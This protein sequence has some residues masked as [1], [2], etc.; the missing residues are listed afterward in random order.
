MATCKI[1]SIVLIAVLLLCSIILLRPHHAHAIMVGTTANAGDVIINEVQY[2]PP[3]SGTDAAWEWVELYNPTNASVDLSGWTIGDNAANDSVPSFFLPPGKFAI[4]AA[5]ANF[6][7]NFP[8][9]TCTIVYMADGAIGNGLNNTGDRVILKDSAG[10]TIDAISYGTDTTYTTLPDVAAGH[11]LER[12][13][14][15]GSFI[16]NPNPSPCPSS[17]TATATPS[18]TPTATPSPSPTSTSTPT[19]SPTST[20]TPT[21]SPTSTS[22]PTASPT[23]TPT[24]EVQPGDVN[25]DGIINCI[26]ITQCELCILDPVKYLKENYPGWDADGNGEGPNSADILAI[27]LR[28]LGLWLP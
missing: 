2:D 21:T 16:D 19:T 15:G 26:D 7:D 23:S 9:C 5:A 24:F 28:I 22:T 18:L 14:A 20:S 6:S 4:I 27:V 25:L 13:P 8:G 3:Q 1:A 12:S 11:S 17:P 10:T